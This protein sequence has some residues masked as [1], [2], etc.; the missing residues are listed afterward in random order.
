M[1]GF[2]AEFG[3]NWQPSLTWIV[4]MLC[5][6]YEYQAMLE[7]KEMNGQTRWR[8]M[9]VDGISHRQILI[10]VQHLRQFSIQLQWIWEDG[11]SQTEWH[12]KLA[13]EM[14]Q[15]TTRP[16]NTSWH[17]T[18]SAESNSSIEAHQ[19]DLHSF[20]S[21]LR[22]T[23]II[24]NLFLLWKWR[25]TSWTFASLLPKVGSRTA[26]VPR[27]LHYHIRCVPGR[28]QLGGISHLFR[29]SAFPLPHIGGAW[30]AHQQ[31]TTT[32]TNLCLA[33]RYISKVMP[34]YLFINC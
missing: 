6:S 26:T 23:D 28:W 16:Q 33:I 15:W 31:A 13:F 30:R 21:S 29:A 5:N 22:W 25:G 11:S 24:S 32:T 3:R 19:T 9:E 7:L 12:C 8:K 27:W 14:L 4:E 2:A 34:M 1:K 10:W 17:S 18:A 20:I